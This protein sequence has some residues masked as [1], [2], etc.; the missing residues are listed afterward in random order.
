M[1][2]FGGEMIG[3]RI[4]GNPFSI[5]DWRAL[6]HSI[7][8]LGEILPKGKIEMKLLKMKLLFL[9]QS[10]EGGG[11]NKEKATRFLHLVNS[12]KY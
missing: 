9:F 10:S 7:F 11:K 6:V 5:G 8:F 2:S 12:Q 1:T 3:T 4:N